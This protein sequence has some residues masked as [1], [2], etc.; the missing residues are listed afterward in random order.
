MFSESSLKRNKRTQEYAPSVLT[1]MQ[2][3]WQV[4]QQQ[5]VPG[6]IVAVGGK[7]QQV[8][9]LVAETHM[10]IYIFDIM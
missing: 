3:R 10:R 4:N 7:Q 2:R 1:G 8:S 9:L 6:I 5:L